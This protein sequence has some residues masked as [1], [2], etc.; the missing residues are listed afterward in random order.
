[1]KT[2]EIRKS[3][4]TSNIDGRCHSNGERLKGRNLGT[5]KDNPRCALF[6]RGVYGVRRVT[7]YGLRALIEMF[8]GRKFPSAMADLIQCAVLSFF[9]FKWNLV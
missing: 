9:L 2:S 7:G 1:M 6:R 8:I 4:Y 3:L 5:R